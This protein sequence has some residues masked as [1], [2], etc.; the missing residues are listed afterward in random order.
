MNT[1]QLCVR[2]RA[3]GIPKQQTGEIIST[4]VRWT[5]CSGPEWTVQHLKSLKIEY[6]HR[7]S[8]NPT[9]APYWKHH[10]DGLPSGVWHWLFKLSGKKA[11]FKV[12]N[13]LMVYSSLQAPEVTIAQR[14]KFFGSMESKDTTGLNSTLKLVTKS[15][16]VKWKSRNPTVF[17]VCTSSEKNAPG[18][19]AYSVRQDDVFSQ[20]MFFAKSR[21]CQL[22]WRKYPLAFSG[23]MPDMLC[24]T[25]RDFVTLPFD[26]THQM[27]L[28]MDRIHAVQ[29]CVGK[30]GL[31]QEPG[32]KLRAVAVPNGILQ[33]ALEPLKDLVLKDLQLCFPTDCT[34]DQEAGVEAVQEW[35]KQGKVCFSVDLSDA[36]NL[37]PRH[38]Q[39]DLLRKRFGHLGDVISQR[40][41]LFEEVSSSEWYVCENEELSIHRFTRGQPLGLGPSF[42]V[43]ALA[44]NVLVTGICRKHG[45][46]PKDCFRILGDDIV[47]SD[48]DIHRVYREV[49]KN[50]G[51]VVSLPKTLVSDRC[52][53]F[54]GKVI[55]PNR[56]ISTYKWHRVEMK[57]FI[58]VA[59]EYGPWSIGL[60]TRAQRKL[61]GYIQEV[62]EDLG[63]LGWNPSGKPLEDRLSS[64]A[65]QAMLERA[66]HDDVVVQYRPLGTL[67]NNFWKVVTTSP[68]LPRFRDQILVSDQFADQAILPG[69]AF[70]M[71]KP[72]DPTRV[73]KLDT[74]N[75]PILVESL[76]RMQELQKRNPSI[77]LDAVYVVQNPKDLNYMKPYFSKGYGLLIPTATHHI[78]DPR[79][80]RNSMMVEIISAMKDHSLLTEG[81]F[82][83][84][85][86]GLIQATKR[87]T[88]PL[89]SREKMKSSHA[90]MRTGSV[91][92]R[93][94]RRMH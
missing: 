85:R 56:V 80:A 65:A 50:L 92:S 58:S 7:L 90:Q 38:L 83:Q 26:R 59:K 10:A 77:P 71:P 60:L 44:H 27:R 67:Y 23:I 45:K 43:F 57:S 34:H 73:E 72:F 41:S 29:R 4:L 63:G 6:L 93:C 61:I 15:P 39:V 5:E 54:A 3:L 91:K 12:L 42:P 32:Y 24:H 46:D 78:G 36:T 28:V 69:M 53:E 76:H 79:Y 2:L 81:E 47:I 70:K 48:A 68:L 62:P 35:L 8:G 64:E 66:L 55:T 21:V 16:I 75:H 31:I 30:I 51:C 52:A 14:T 40:I 25:M 9:P 84:L 94:G 22:L 82:R 37:F 86:K 20:M 17:E 18:P 88:S 19:E 1:R 87:R 33:T 49:L 11:A 13:T 74:W 89:H